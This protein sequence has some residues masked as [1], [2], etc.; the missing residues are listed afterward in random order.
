MIAYL[1][2]ASRKIMAYGIYEHP[3]TRG[4]IE[5]YLKAASKY[6]DPDAVLTDRDPTF[7][8]TGSNKKKKGTSTFERFLIERG[9]KH[10][11]GRVNHPQ[12]NGKIERFYGTLEQKLPLFNN[13]IHELIHWYNNT[14]YHMSLEFNGFYETPN[15]AFQRKLPPEKILGQAMEVIFND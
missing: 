10:I 4:A 8:A 14:K 9:V 3:N 13:N 11:V 1:D 12:T 15:Q 5:V 2:D 6:G 7:Y